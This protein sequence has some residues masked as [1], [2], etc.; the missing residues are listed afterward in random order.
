MIRGEH[1]WEVP[2]WVK[3]QNIKVF[4][5]PTPE[6]LIKKLKATEVNMRRSSETSENVS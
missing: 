5:V 1:I 6:E 3:T 4:Y 2:G